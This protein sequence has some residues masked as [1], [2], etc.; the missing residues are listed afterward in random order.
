MADRRS[1]LL[2]VLDSC[3]A[4]SL[5]GENVDALAGFLGTK[6]QTRHAHATWTLPA[7]ASILS[8]LLPHAAGPED[9]RGTPDLYRG[10]LR[11]LSES[12]G[13][14]LSG[15]AEDYLPAMWIPSWLRGA[16]YRTLASVALPVLNP[17][18]IV[19]RHG[20]SRYAHE[21]EGLDRQIVSLLEDRATYAG[22]THYDRSG[23]PLLVPP[24][25]FFALI[26]A[27]ETHYPYASPAV[28]P[29]PMP[30][31]SG[32]HGA[33]K[34]LSEGV[35]VSVPLDI[36]AEDMVRMHA[37]QTASANWA[38]GRILRLVREDLAPGTR[39]TVT[40]DH[41]ECFGEGGWFGHGPV[42]HD[43]VLRVPYLDG[44]VGG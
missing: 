29:T 3:R 31:L 30:W 27:K 14:P 11:E 28:L 39:V 7:H 15:G 16:G 37:R 6:V 40:A 13:V 25:P 2:V 12:L 22:V 35:G 42:A 23:R 26:N 41:G 43:A 1:W 4:D 33:A 18:T 24:P 32:L 19:A 36:T 10:A 21:T 8:G 9:T 17:A 38:A 34:K 5:V 44:I 20:W